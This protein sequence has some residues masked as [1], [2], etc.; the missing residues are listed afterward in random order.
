MRVAV[1]ISGLTKNYNYAYPFIKANILDVYKPDVFI[2]SWFTETTRGVTLD[3]VDA[4][5][6]VSIMTEP[7]KRLKLPRTYV[8]GV[9]ERYPA[10]NIFSLFRSIFQASSLRRVHEAYTGNYDWVFR[11]RFDYAVNRKFDLAV[12]SPEY[13]HVPT[14]LQDRN[15]ITDQFAFGGQRVMDQYSDTFLELDRF[16]SQYKIP[17][18][19]EH[20]IS[21]Q[22]NAQIMQGKVEYHDMNHP[23]FPVAP[24]AMRHSM[25]R[26]YCKDQVID[27]GIA[28]QDPTL[29]TKVSTR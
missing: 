16:Y 25:V 6:P 1:E 22:M 26:D 4:Y 20:M 3:A 7:D 24:D 21:T 29:T 27:G 10:Y 2:H 18:V 14:E 28:P 8:N 5:K 12:L 11:L 17:M 15:M 13:L 19:G 23:F 9:S